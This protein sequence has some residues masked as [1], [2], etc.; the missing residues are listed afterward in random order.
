MSLSRRRFLVLSSL[1]IAGAGLAFATGCRGKQTAHVLQKDDADMVGSHAAGGEVY[2]PL[3]DEAVAK[4][5]GRHEHGANPVDLA[6]TAPQPMRICFIG[7]ENRSSEEIGDFKEQIYQLIDSH[8]SQST[9]YQPINKRMVDAALH[10]SRMRP[11]Q[12]MVPANQEVF[13]GML[14]QQGQ[15]IDFL[16]YAVITSG[17]TKNNGDY[18][19]DYLLTLE[20]VNIHTG[21]YDKESAALS[22][23]YHKSLIGKVKNYGF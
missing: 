6:S 16:L 17:T 5:L 23:G 3:I 1:G 21:D 4:L 12:L 14:G 7:V 13:V 22:K 19:R 10:E 15:P 9:V 2:K 8:I 18:Q 11:D 20:M